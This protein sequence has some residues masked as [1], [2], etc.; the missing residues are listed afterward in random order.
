MKEINH[1]PPDTVCNFWRT[2]VSHHLLIAVFY[3][4]LL[5]SLS[6]HNRHAQKLNKLSKV[7]C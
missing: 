2:F 3:I 6:S 4:F 5:S 7:P 1:K